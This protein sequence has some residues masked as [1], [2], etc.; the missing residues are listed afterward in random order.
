MSSHFDRSQLP[1]VTRRDGKI[2][3]TLNPGQAKLL[4]A[5][6][7]VADLGDAAHGAWF[8][9]LA[10]MASD[11][12]NL[13]GSVA[14]SS[15]SP[16]AAFAEALQDDEF[17]RE[18]A[19]SVEAAS[20]RAAALAEQAVLL[21]AR[22]ADAAAVAA[23][24]ACAAAATKAAT[25]MADSVRLQAL[26]VQDH[27]NVEAR[28][29]AAAAATAAARVASAVLPGH[30]AEAR[31]AAVHVAQIATETAASTAEETALVAATTAR[32]AAAAALDA[33]AA[34]ADAAM[35]IE[36]EVRSTAKA[37][38]DTATAAAVLVSVATSTAAGLLDG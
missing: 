34:A 12:A 13:Y 6:I 36:L 15:T 28:E 4:A 33:A 21:A 8:D 35:W 17:E 24:Q 14:R 37:V 31:R 10:E 26:A 16:T 3:L 22:T 1:D 32:A 9:T 20:T 5:T 30:E 19:R 27:A 25:M 18:A 38:Q 2:V 29:V 11:A 23:Q 7:W